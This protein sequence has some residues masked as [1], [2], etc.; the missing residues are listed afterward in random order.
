MKLQEKE[1]TMPSSA[2]ALQHRPAVWLEYLATLAL[3]S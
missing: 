1:S 2:I 3:A